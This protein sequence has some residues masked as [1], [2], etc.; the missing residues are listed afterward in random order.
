M[1]PESIGAPAPARVAA[2]VAA[3]RR[4]L[5]DQPVPC[6][7]HLRVRVRDR[8]R[9]YL[10]G[11]QTALRPE[12]AVLQWR[13]APLAAAFFGAAEGES[14]EIAIDGRVAEGTVLERH[15]IELDRGELKR[16]VP[17][18]AAWVPLRAPDQRARPS[19]PIE[20]PLDAVQLRAVRAPPGGAQL[21]LGEAGAG[22]TT[23]ALHRLAHLAA[24]ARAGWRAL[25][26]VPTE[27]LKRLSELML[28]RLGVP[29]GPITVARYDRWAAALA[30]RAYRG[31]PRG[32]SQDAGAGVLRLKRHRALQS[33]L[34]V[35]A[36]RA[37]DARADREDLLHLF[38][39]R[40]AMERAAAAAHG[41]LRPHD[42]Y[43]VLEHTRIQFSKTTEQEFSHV[44]D[45]S[46]LETLDGRAIDSGTP[47]GD[48][49]TI[50]V[51][52]YAVLF[53]I[54][55]LRARAR[56]KR[57]PVL[58]H[59]YDAV[60]VDEAQEFAPLELALIGRSL[61]RRGTLIVA[62]DAAQ[63]VD[64]AACFAGW[65]TAMGDLR[66]ARHAET[67]LDTSYRCPPEVT[68]LARHVLDPARPLGLE[69]AG[70]RA[71]GAARVH[72]ISCD[73][74]C[75]LAAWIAEGLR[76]IDEQDP[77]ASVAVIAR[78]PGGARRWA[79]ALGR[80]VSVQLALDGDF[81]FGRG[82][83]VTCVA[84]VKGLEFD[85]VIVPDAWP[86]VYPDEPEA[87]RAMYVALTRAVHAVAIG[88]VGRSS[89]VLGALAAAQGH[90]EWRSITPG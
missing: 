53:E 11:P 60:V 20:V 26:V 39:D 30:R 61:A 21:I 64:P 81:R 71:R 44:I 52:D 54:D 31:L 69:T 50:D 29:V 57:E 90:A 8:E 18:D 55:R 63:Q 87:R 78:T 48:A 32:E 3:A 58:P 47:M 23:V 85:Y 16:L 1:E 42:V 66:A 75:H 65:S 80:A 10:L 82:T 41:E 73:N 70:T 40:P 86:S 43:E 79:H 37:L 25:V 38:G 6:F 24:E 89:A 13:E 56:G 35:A 7:A 72:A 22:K 67:R 33:E 76:R 19:S 2:L 5:P 9:D 62:G 74:E 84:E 49:A 28:D 4:A 36:R 46:R 51:E 17:V 77:H 12:I 83:H 27:G 59:R 14:Y 45:A 68:A 88:A 34:E 15:L